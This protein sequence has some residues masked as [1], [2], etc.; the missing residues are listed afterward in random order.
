M[1][2]QITAIPI[3]NQSDKKLRV[4]DYCRVSTEREE[5]RQSLKWYPAKPTG[6]LDAETEDEVLKIL[7]SLAHDENKCVII[8]TH[9]E[10]VTLVADEIWGIEEGMLS[11]QRS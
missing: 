10:N 4:N 5:Q 1:S 3:K 8:V 9:S 7:V 2:K 6:N 11:K